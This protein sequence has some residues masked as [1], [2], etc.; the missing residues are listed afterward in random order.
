MTSVFFDALIEL[1]I[2][3]QVAQVVNDQFAKVEANCEKI[4]GM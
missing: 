1:G 3:A 4:V 2:P